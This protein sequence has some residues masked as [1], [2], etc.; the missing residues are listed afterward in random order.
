MIEYIK[1]SK[2]KGG[3]SPR[4][5]VEAPDSL[6]SI[7]YAKVL[8]LVSE[9]PIGGLVDGLK[10]VYL[11]D[12]ALQNDDSTYNFTGVQFTSVAGTQDQPS[13]PGFPGVSAETA[14]GVEVKSALPVTRQITN[15]N[16]DG[17]GVTIG[18][19]QLTNQNMTNGDINGTE[20]KLTIALSTDGGESWTDQPISLIDNAAGFSTTNGIT[21]CSVASTYFSIQVDWAGAQNS[22]YSPAPAFG[23]AAN[24]PLQQHQV[25]LQY[26]LVG[27]TSWTSYATATFSGKT[28]TSTYN[29]GG[30]SSFS[31]LG[32]P[33]IVYP[34]GSKTFTLSLPLG[35]YQFRLQIIYNGTSF[36]TGLPYTDGTSSI[37]I[38]KSTARVARNFDIISGKT[39]TK[40]QRTYRINVPSGLSDYRIRVTKNTPD[41][42]TSNIINK[43]NWD[44]YTEILDDKLS[45]PNSAIMAVSVDASQFNKIPTRAYEI[46]GLKIKIPSNYNPITR[47]YS[48]IWDGSFVIGWTDNPAWV[49]YDLVT[50]TRYGL[51]SYLSANMLDKWSL[52]S[53]A[54]YCDEFVPDGITAK[55]GYEPRF[56]CNLYLQ[57]A[58]EAYRVINN[59]ASIF[60]S[61]VYWNN[62][63]LMVAQDKPSPAIALYTPANVV[64]GE[65]TYQG[66]SLKTRHTTVLVS[67]ND[68]NDGYKTKQEYV[69]DLDG[70]KRYGVLETQIAAMGCT[71]RGQAHRIGKWL[72]YTER[73]ETETISFKTGL[74]SALVYPGA[75]IQTQDAFRTGTRYG[76]RIVSATTNIIN[77]DSPVTLTLGKEYKISCTLE[78][79]TLEVHSVI[80][81]GTTTTQL[82]TSTDFKD[83]PK[84]IWILAEWVTLTSGSTSISLQKLDTWRVISITETNV[85]ELQI[86]AVEHHPEKFLE[87]EKDLQFQTVNTVPI[88]NNSLKPTWHPEPV[89]PT[90][91]KSITETLY[92]SGVNS[93]GIKLQLAWIGKATS[94]KIEYKRTN[95]NWITLYSNT[96]DVE[97]FGDIVE[98]TYYFRVS[99]LNSLKME[100]PMSDQL[101]YTVLGKSIPPTAINE[102]TIQINANAYG[103]FLDWDPCN[104]VDF[105]HYE[106][107]EGN[108]WVG[109]SLVANNIKASNHQI[110]F[111]TVGLHNYIIRA[112]DT[113]GNYS[114]DAAASITITKPNAVV[115]SSQI[116][117]N[118]YKLSWNQP[119]VSS[120]LVKEYK[121][122]VNGSLVATTPALTYTLTPPSGSSISYYIV[123]VDMGN[124]ESNASTTGTT[125]VSVSAPVVSATD[126]IV[127]TYSI[128]WT[129]PTST[130]PV[131]SYEIG[132]NSTSNIVGLPSGTTFNYKIP[133]GA[134]HNFYI[135]AI[136]VLGNR[137]TATQ[138]ILNITKP[139]SPVVTNSVIDNNVLLYWND[140]AETLPIYTYEIHRGASY[141]YPP[142][143][144]TKTGLFTSLFE[145]VAGNYTYWITAVDVA[146]NKST[147]RAVTLTISQPPDYVLKVNL[148]STLNG[149][150]SNTFNDTLGI[151]GPT[152][153]T[154]QFQTHFTSTTHGGVVSTAWNTPQD[155]ITAGFPIYIQPN[156]STGYYE[157]VIDYGGLLASSKI[158][159]TPTIALV[160]G[161]PSIT[162]D[163]YTSLDGITYNPFLN[164]NSVFATNFR[165]IKFRL[166]INTSYNTDLLRITGINIKLDQKLKS[167]AG[168]AIC[169]AADGGSG[170]SATVTLNAGQITG[171]TSIVGGSGYSQTVPPSVN[172]TGNGIGAVIKANVSVGGA[173]TGFTILNAGSGYTSC[174]ISISGAGTVVPW[175]NGIS[176]TDISSLSVSA[177]GTSNVTA[178]YDFADLPNP[179]GFRILL[180]NPSTGA[181][182]SGTASWNVKGY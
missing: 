14:V 164:T 94:Y 177:S 3:G 37:N 86:T 167:D 67:W 38:T 160:A 82:R 47:V 23:V 58:E 148:D 64:D 118:D 56:T 51:G 53:I 136:D 21:T 43:I 59:L 139:G 70:I 40:Y 144:G 179:A 140:T 13:I 98:D 25:T 61:I 107:R 28:T 134:V 90:D 153:N 109:S 111:P 119:A 141:S 159:V 97:I 44:S 138:Q 104:D 60:R 166:T 145:T 78:D 62:N 74:D 129:T 116:V 65:F 34:K 32:Q 161:N 81:T 22:P 170:A 80:N 39:I 130:F 125:N 112:V 124:I 147:P 11:D 155:Q 50:N 89:L 172:I 83:T 26:A 49:F 106:I 146:N 181:R 121:V 63:T 102:S 87:V 55:G 72:L 52:Y 171:F 35:Q 75:I 42:T 169:T 48:G 16:I 41:S 30:A 20:V 57:T 36:I 128:T 8:D 127:D 182:V 10:S 114:T 15:T 157:E 105:S 33:N 168:M 152:N 135:T 95:G 68:P 165:Y 73:Y 163:L 19:P 103:V 175:N 84:G 99:G 96:A 29:W 131:A 69:E 12:T 151:L 18:I 9:G 66:S 176:F 143:I 110:P 6:R 17:I 7:Q 120:Y 27:S 113:S 91:P 137:S 5:A 85:N 149:T 76:G 133:N 93:I 108:E 46:Y 101:T 126:V 24:N 173:V 123:T 71:S 88:T 174:T 45:Y 100:S 178:L 115:P 77:I 162:T 122:Y 158:T 150:L 154:E 4:V 180:L 79:G 31:T 1:G 156:N 2:G 142:N 54:Q 132:Y 92:V 117:G